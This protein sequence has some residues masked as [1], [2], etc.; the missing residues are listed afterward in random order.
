MDDDGSD[1]RAWEQRRYEAEALNPNKPYMRHA[2]LLP[3]RDEFSDLDEYVTLL[4]HF[5]TLWNEGVRDEFTWPDP[6]HRERRGNARAAKRLWEKRR[7][8]HNDERGDAVNSLI[9]RA[10][11]LAGLAPDSHMRNV[12]LNWAAYHSREDIAAGYITKDEVVKLLIDA[13]KVNGLWRDDGAIS[14]KGTI[15]SGLGGSL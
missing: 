1:T 11:W 4:K 5:A 15:M 12:G 9:G 14:V 3:L 6:S 13:C 8:F 10:N 2:H 7:F